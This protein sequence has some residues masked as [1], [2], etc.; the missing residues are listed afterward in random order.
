MR[1]QATAL[2]L[3]AL[4]IPPAAYAVDPEHGGGAAIPPTGGVAAPDPTTPDPSE[5][6]SPPLVPLDASTPPSGG[7]KSDQPAASADRPSARSA[8]DD[9]G[10]TEVEVPTPGAEPGSA[11]AGSA[12]VDGSGLADTGLEVPLILAAGISMLG[13]GLLVL[14]LVRRPR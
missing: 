13:A 11:D 5:P 10:Y 12:T 8:Q 1:L 14:G 2:L 9:D 4:A 3:V 6:T 7:E